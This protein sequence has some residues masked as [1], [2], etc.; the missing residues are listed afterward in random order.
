MTK[1]QIK[2]HKLVLFLS[3]LFTPF[4]YCSF[5]YTQKRHLFSGK[6]KWR[7]IHYHRVTTALYRSYHRNDIFSQAIT[8]AN[9][10]NK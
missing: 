5:E 3:F 9:E 4:L 7:F 6:N 1:V 8:T 2:S 10:P